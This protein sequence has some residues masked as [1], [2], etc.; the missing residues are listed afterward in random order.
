MSLLG[1]PPRRPAL[2]TVYRMPC[3]LYDETDDRD[4]PLLVVSVDDVTRTAR[5][6]TRTSTYEA[7]GPKPVVHAKHPDLDL[8]RVGWWRMHILHLVPWTHFADPDVE[9]LGTIDE[10]TWRN[11]VQALP[12]TEETS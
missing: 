12:G 5:A 2:R 6:V 8:D 10:G 9:V 1:F 4:H 3:S 11:V 7:R